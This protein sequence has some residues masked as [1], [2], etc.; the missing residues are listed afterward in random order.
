MRPPRAKTW[1]RQGQTPVVRVRAGGH[2]RASIAGMVCYKTG[3]CSRLIYRV[4]TW[5]GRKG[6]TK[7]F[8]WAE[9]RDLV[10]FAHAQLGAPIVLIWD[11]LGRHTCP[12]MQQFLA[13]HEQWLTVFQLP[14]YTPDLNPV[15]GIWSLLQRAALANLAVASFGH[16]VRVIKRGLKKIQYR[17]HLIDGCLAETGLI[18]HPP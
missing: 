14:S 4:H 11:N 1:G 10:V 3:E 13:D 8:T 5:R 18:L 9:Y 12:Q 6:E 2:G 17:P 16:L 7:S 15:E